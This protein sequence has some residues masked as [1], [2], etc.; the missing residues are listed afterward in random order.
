MELHEILAAALDAV[1]RANVPDDL[2]ETA[3][4]KAVDMAAARHGAGALGGTDRGRHKSLGDGAR[5]SMNAG[6]EVGDRLTRIAEALELTPEEVERVYTEHDDELQIVADPDDL[7]STGKER[8]IH[9]ALLLATGRQLGGYDAA[10]TGDEAIREEITRLHLFDRSNYITHMKTL[11]TW[12]N[13]NGSGK[14]ATY[15]LKHAGR[16]EAKRLAKALA[17]E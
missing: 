8:S 5:G 2:R 14:S 15:R 7:G 9:T 11:S 16:T 17:G 3:F 6:A 4:A 13:I 1:E 10:A 12:F